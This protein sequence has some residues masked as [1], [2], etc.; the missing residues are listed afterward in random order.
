MNSF[1]ADKRVDVMNEWSY[2]YAP[3][4]RHHGLQRQ[5]SLTPSISYFP[6]PFL[7]FFLSTLSL[8]INLFFLCLPSL[9]F[10]PCLT[11]ATCVILSVRFYLFQPAPIPTDTLI[12]PDSYWPLTFCAIYNDS[13]ANSQLSYGLYRQ[14]KCSSRAD[15]LLCYKRTISEICNTL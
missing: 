1:P 8:Y 4:I 3:P 5:I 9:L 2:T 10:P 7:Y 15:S 12:D 14:I 11:F 13:A 6:L